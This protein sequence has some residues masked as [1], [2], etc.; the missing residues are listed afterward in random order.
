MRSSGGVVGLMS[1]VRQ[2]ETR[3]TDAEKR[4]LQT[5]ADQAVIAIE[6]SRLFHEL[7]ESNREVS[8]ALEQQTAV[9]AVLQTISR[10]AFDLD[11]VLDELAEQAHRLVKGDTTILNVYRGHELVPAASSGELDDATA[12]EGLAVVSRVIDGGR[13]V[14]F[15]A[16][17]GEFS[18]EFP[19]FGTMMVR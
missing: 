17:V 9:A 5:F 4:V 18:T 6:N 14:Y 11:T 12:S 13:A 8:A 2:G 10:S 16:R 7:E 1:V 19:A 3:F 15:T